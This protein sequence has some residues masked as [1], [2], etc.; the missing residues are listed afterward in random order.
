MGFKIELT[1]KGYDQNG[2]L[3]AERKV[4]GDL[5]LNNFKNW[6]AAVLRPEENIASASSRT[7]SLTDTGGTARSVPVVSSKTITGGSG[8][9]FNYVNANWTYGCRIRIGTGTATPARTDYALGAEV[10]TGIPT[11]TIGADYIIWAVS[12]TLASAADITEAGLSAYWN[13]ADGATAAY[14]NFLLTRDTFTAVSVPAGGTISV[15]I[16]FT[17]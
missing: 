8:A 5:L 13:Y 3:I 10:A 17:F 12:I 9:I 11:Q 2:K 6:L 4:I 16:K 15:T 14:A 1:V 7:V